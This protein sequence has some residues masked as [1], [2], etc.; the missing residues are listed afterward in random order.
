[1][2]GI[3]SHGEG[4]YGT[5]PY[6][7]NNTDIRSMVIYAPVVA[8]QK[9]LGDAN[10][11]TLDVDQATGTSLENG[12]RIKCIST[13]SVVVGF[14]DPT[15]TRGTTGGAGFELED[16]EELFLEVRDLGHVRV[17]GNGATITYIAS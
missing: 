4:G 12:V 17:K 13:T 6:R 15:T 7:L 11:N 3:T 10:W 14:Y 16:R 9:T 1:M 5:P 8:D 2:A